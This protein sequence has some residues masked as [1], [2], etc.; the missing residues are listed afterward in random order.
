MVYEG[1][2]A[3]DPRRQAKGP[4]MELEVD[5]SEKYIVLHNIVKTFE[6]FI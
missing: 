1:V 2:S 4:V 3:L 5:T 6:S